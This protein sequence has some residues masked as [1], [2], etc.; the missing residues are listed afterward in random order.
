LLQ[1]A[2]FAASVQASQQ[3]LHSYTATQPTEY[4]H[5]GSGQTPVA[6]SCKQGNE[7]GFHK[8]KGISRL[9]EDCL[10]HNEEL[11]GLN[12]SSNVI[13]VIKSR[14]ERWAG[15]VERRGDRRGAYRVLVEKREGKRPLVRP[16]WEDNIKWIFKK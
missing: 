9:A 10:L 12:S 6:V 16:R 4:I 13:R 2:L 7:L 1:Y 11:Y 3:Q 14:R 8:S 15:H 5:L